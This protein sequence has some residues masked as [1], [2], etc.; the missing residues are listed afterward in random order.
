MCVGL[1]QV[2][3]LFKCRLDFKLGPKCNKFI[4]PKCVPRNIKGPTMVLQAYTKKLL[5]NDL[6]GLSSVQSHPSCFVASFCSSRD[7]IKASLCDDCLYH[8]G[9]RLMGNWHWRIFHR[10]SRKYWHTFNIIIICM[11]INRKMTRMSWTRS[12]F[13]MTDWEWWVRQKRVKDALLSMLRKCT[14]GIHI[15]IWSVGEV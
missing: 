4:I 15:F 7:I 14:R 12:E 2:A 6:L 10:F 11:Y 5:T 9:R 8:W 3:M 1:G 13:M